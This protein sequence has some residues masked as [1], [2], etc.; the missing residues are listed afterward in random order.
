[1]TEK[2]FISELL[3]RVMQDSFIG[4]PSDYYGLAEGQPTTSGKPGPALTLKEFEDAYA[5]VKALQPVPK[6]D[7]VLIKFPVQNWR[8]RFPRFKDI[9]S[10][11]RIGPFD[12]YFFEPHING[13]PVDI[14]PEVPYN[15]VW[16]IARDG[17]KMILCTDGVL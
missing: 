9:V 5:K 15:E 2:D 6:D 14:N 7:F 1:M 4:K 11:G 3:F 12:S 10:Q 8:I 17:T 13:I 16:F